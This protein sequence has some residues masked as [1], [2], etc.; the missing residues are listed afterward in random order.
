M[1]YFLQDSSLHVPECTGVCPGR[2]SASA[3]FE[4]S[5]EFEGRWLNNPCRSNRSKIWICTLKDLA[6]GKVFLF[7]RPNVFSW[8]Q[9]PSASPPASTAAA[10]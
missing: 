2:D 10:V 5:M 6:E 4:R 9:R 1:L 8:A 3:E 7:R